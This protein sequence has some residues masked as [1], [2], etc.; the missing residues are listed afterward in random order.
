MPST[1]EEEKRTVDRSSGNTSRRR[2]DA[3]TPSNG[4]K[5]GQTGGGVTEGRTNRHP[6]SSRR[7]FLRGGAL[8]VGATVFSGHVGATGPNGGGQVREIDS[9]TEITEPGRY[10]LTEDLEASGG[11]CLV[12]NADDV[13]LD[14]GGH[15]I[16]NGT[17]SGATGIAVGDYSGPG[18]RNVAVRH[19]TITD[20]RGAGVV[21]GDVTGG[22]VRNVTVKRCGSGLWL[23][24][25]HDVDVREN[26]LSNNGR[27]IV[28]TENSTGNVLRS[29]TVSDNAS[30]G[31]AIWD[32]GTDTQLVRNTVTDNGT[33]GIDV[34]EGSDNCRLTDNVS[35]HNGG[36]GF[37]LTDD[38]TNARLQG[39]LAQHNGENGITLLLADG[40][41]LIRNT[42]K[43]NDGHGIELR[44]AHDNHLIRNELCDNG[45]EPISEVFGSSGNE[46]RA[47]VTSC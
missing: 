33:N 14:G 46:L 43:Q 47:N 12:I 20:F 15:T 23:E 3:T 41:K 17:S 40:N 45:G 36:S 5:A 13:R 1:N 35:K 37:E 30:V 11:V 4:S 25:S 38:V 39:N 44:N 22:R 19:L 24:Q 32:A 34:A 29:N 18:V 16:S 21:H 27:G 10:V 42:A 2:Q 26:E 7:T 6:N 8:A 28:V 9:C 31:I